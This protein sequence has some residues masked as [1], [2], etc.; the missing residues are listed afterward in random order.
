MFRGLYIPTAGLLS[1]RA[2]EPEKLAISP[3]EK[4]RCGSDAETIA[5]E[6][7]FKSLSAQQ[8]LSPFAPTKPMANNAKDFLPAE[9]S[10][11]IALKLHDHSDHSAPKRIGCRCNM[12]KCLRLHCRCF[13]DLDY[14]ARNC[15][16]TDCFN[17]LQ[18]EEARAFV[19]SKT[20]EINPHAFTPK[21]L[22]AEG[23]PA[24]KF[25][26]DGC[27]CKTG[28]SRNYCECFKSGVACSP[29]CRCNECLNRMAP[30]QASVV[31]SITKR[32][33]RKKNKLTITTIGKISEKDTSIVLG[34]ASNKEDVT[35]EGE[36]L[37]RRVIT[38]GECVVEFKSYKRI[39]RDQLEDFN[40]TSRTLN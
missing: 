5:S 7:L 25:N 28:C 20:K 34:E 18:F 15:K 22:P 30:S 27:T 33:T 13:K 14:C 17:Q 11:Q 12:S 40:R 23:V 29:L 10:V 31:N 16:C 37:G 36:E 35:S 21:L 19:I 24:S 8:V 26:A 39:K 1:F 4:S 6:P 2:F 32:P 9:H 3:V 38:T